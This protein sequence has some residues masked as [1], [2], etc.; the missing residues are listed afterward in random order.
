M[1]GTTEVVEIPVRVTESETIYN[2]ILFVYGP[3]ALHGSTPF[4]PPQPHQPRP[5][6]TPRVEVLKLKERPLQLLEFGSIKPYC[7]LQDQL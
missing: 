4:H 6:W 3:R 2:T 1:F 7:I 5:T